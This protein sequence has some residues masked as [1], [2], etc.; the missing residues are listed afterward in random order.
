MAS[1]DPQEFCGGQAPRLERPQF[2]AIVSSETLAITPAKK[3]NGAV[4]GFIVESGLAGGHNAPPRG[5]RELDARGQPVYG[6]RDVVDFEKIRELGRPFWLAGIQVGTD[7][8]FFDES[9]IAPQWTREVR[10]SSRAGD[11]QVFTD[12]AA[13]PTGF[14]FKIAEVPG[15]L[16]QREICQA[17]GRFC[18]LGY[19]R[20]LYRK[21]DGSVG[22]RC[23]GEPVDDYVRKGGNL[24][25]RVGRKCLCNGLL[26]TVGLGQSRADG[27]EP[28]LVT[29]G[30]ELTDLGRLLGPDDDAFSAADVIRYLRGAT[31]GASEALTEYAK[32]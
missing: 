2:L 4:D 14:P 10:R 16:L 20:Q 1:F 32:A 25:D 7:F 11:A 29:A 15:T 12:P 6:P 17:R 23:S 21:S 27:D 30:D 3:S 5:T 24:A 22:Y 9:G 8:A 18:D 26:A 31:T 19:L 13:S 28:A